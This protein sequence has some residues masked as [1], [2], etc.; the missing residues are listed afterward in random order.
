[1]RH[2]QPSP[3]RHIAYVLMPLPMENTKGIYSQSAV[4]TDASKTHQYASPCIYVFTFCCRLFIAPLEHAS[5]LHLYYN[6]VSLAWK[7]V[8]LE[9]Q[10]GFGSIK[11]AGLILLFQAMTGAIY[12]FL[13]YLAAEAL[14]DVSYVRQCAVGFSAVLFAL[15]VVANHEDPTTRSHGNTHFLPA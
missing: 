12:T 5:D 10:H 15:K 3:N 14:D 1:M 6:M 13:A 8:K 11:F 9:T 7:G 2:G 4:T